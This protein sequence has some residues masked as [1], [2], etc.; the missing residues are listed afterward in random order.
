MQ[1]YPL[2]YALLLLFTLAEAILVGLVS[3]QYTQES[4]V[5]ALTVT[6]AIVFA[7]TLFACQTK[8]DFTGCGPYLFVG[9]L[10]LWA[11]GIFLWLGSF[12]L[13]SSGFATWRLIYA[14]G[15]AFLFSC[16]IVYDTQL[17]IG[18]KH[19]RSFNFDDYVPAAITLY[20]DIVQLFL[21]ILEIFGNRR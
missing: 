12:M 13:G 18:G 8:C 19:R 15:G 10:S 14:C 17:I 11:F 2:N 4:I 5:I 21:F 1:K 7:L 20:V 6:T 16:Y 9:L 3:V